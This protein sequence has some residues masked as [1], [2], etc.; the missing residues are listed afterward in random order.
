MPI[1]GIAL[2]GAGCRLAVANPSSRPRPSPRTTVP[3]SQ[4][5]AAQQPRRLHDLARREQVA[6]PRR[7][8]RCAV[9]LQQRRRLHLEPE[10]LPGCCQR[11]DRCPARGARSG[12][13]APRSPAGHPASR[14]APVRRTARARSVRT[15][16]RTGSRSAR[17]APARP[18]AATCRSGVDS[19]RG[20]SSGRS[21]M[22]GC[23]SN[24]TTLERVPRS[25]AAAIAPLDHAPVAEV[26]A[27]EA[28]QRNGAGDRLGL[29]EAG[30]DH[31]AQHHGRSQSLL[32]RP[33]DRHQPPVVHQPHAV[34]A[35]P[36]PAA[37]ARAAHPRPRG[38]PTARSG[39]CDSAS[40][41]GSSTAR[42]PPPGS[43]QARPPDPP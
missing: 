6:D 15:P 17:R 34:P 21:T 39:R 36:P 31:R 35:H 11:L 20:A 30:L 3:S 4:G 42:R 43:A 8:D 1:A 16:G 12:S 26:D 28:A 19:S 23:G 29:I 25:V 22:I 24:V 9:H 41:A 18:P 37:S 2:R 5:V 33:A 40:A 32:V 27:V 7:R 10:P 14:A 13:C 38:R